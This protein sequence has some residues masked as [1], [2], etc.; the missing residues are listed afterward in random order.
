[1]DMFMVDITNVKAKINDTVL[2]F[3]NA[4]YFAQ[5]TQ[6]SPYEILTNFKNARTKSLIKYE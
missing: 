1:M 2:L 4:N 3:N 6:T 5:I